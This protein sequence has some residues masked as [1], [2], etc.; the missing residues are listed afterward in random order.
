MRP[1]KCRTLANYVRTRACVGAL[2][3]VLEDTEVEDKTTLPEATQHRVHALT[4]EWLL[5]RFKSLA[6]RDLFA[7]AEV[8][9]AA[10]HY[11]ETDPYMRTVSGVKAGC[12]CQPKQAI[13]VRCCAAQAC[14]HTLLAAMSLCELIERECRS[15]SRAQRHDWNST[16]LHA[17]LTNGRL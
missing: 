5:N 14:A 7:D 2:Q 15:C 11:I 10:M 1:Q 6:A 17:R 3:L 9:E 12:S 4:L 16:T 8:L 13:M